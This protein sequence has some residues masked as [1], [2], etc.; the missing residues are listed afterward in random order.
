MKIRYE[1]MGILL[2]DRNNGLNILIDEYK[3][4]T[5]EQTNSPRYVSIALTNDCNLSCSHCFVDH[6]DNYFDF[7]FLCNIALILDK[8]DCFGIG[9]GGGEPFLY[10]KISEICGF[11]HSETKLAVTITT[12]GILIQKTMS[13]WITKNVNFIRL[14]MDGLH[15]N[16]EFLRGIPFKIF[17]EKLGIVKNCVRFGLNILVNDLTVD[18]L[19][20]IA[21]F[22][23]KNKS[24]EILLLP[25]INRQGNLAMKGKSIEKMNCWIESN[26]K[27]LP[28]SIS[29]NAAQIINSPILPIQ[30]NL[31]PNNPEEFVHI[32]SQK[33]L[34][35]SAFD[36][37]GY[38]LKKPEDIIPGLEYLKLNLKG[39]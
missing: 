8:I 1:D 21:E 32:N 18:E 27:L 10:P 5:Q 3:V 17:L 24:S 38:L 19:D 34:K 39:A 23:E 31:L 16:Y 4:T 14:S 13:T 30:N 25:E 7:E 9:L 29:I 28:L 26:Y 33:I 2:F 36:K 11:L 6:G 37:Y 20:D 15:K 35:T 12:N 22:S